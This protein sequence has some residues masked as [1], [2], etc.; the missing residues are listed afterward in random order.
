M[1]IL[2]ISLKPKC[3]QCN[4]SIESELNFNTVLVSVGIMHLSLNQ[5]IRIEFRI[6]G[7]RCCRILCFHSS[8][9]TTKSL[10]VLRSSTFLIF[11]Q[12][13]PP[14]DETFMRLAKE[15]NKRSKFMT[16]WKKKVFLLGVH[17]EISGKVY[18]Q[19]VHLWIYESGSQTCF[20]THQ[21]CSVKLLKESTFIFL[22]TFRSF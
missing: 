17:H 6:E 22:C 16:Q 14:S 3:L 12:N 1:W 20:Y 11:R 2:L 9:N 4:K 10:N 21:F 19:S 15:Q 18:L 5:T 13:P 8:M 7:Q